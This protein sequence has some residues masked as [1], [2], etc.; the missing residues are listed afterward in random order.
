M[1]RR[2]TSATGLIV[3]STLL[4]CTTPTMRVRGPIISRIASMSSSPS[5]VM[6]Q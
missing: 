4:T 5:G 2:A 3:P 1:A 6:G